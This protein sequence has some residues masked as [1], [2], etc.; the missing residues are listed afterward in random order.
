MPLTTL[1]SRG[2]EKRKEVIVVANLIY[3]KLPDG[4]KKLERIIPSTT[5]QYVYFRGGGLL[6]EV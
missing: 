5:K 4:G 6:F 1:E 2:Q 3:K